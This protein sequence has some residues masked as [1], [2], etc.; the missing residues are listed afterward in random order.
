MASNTKLNDVLTFWQSLACKQS[1][2]ATLKLLLE[3]GA[4]INTKDWWEET[5]LITAILYRL[6]HA[7]AILL[8]NGADVNVTTQYGMTALSMV[9]W[10]HTKYRLDRSHWQDVFKQL[11][12]NG[13]DVHAVDNFGRT[14][15]IEAVRDGIDTVLVRLLIEHGADVNARDKDG[16]TPLSFACG[17]RGSLKTAELLRRLGAKE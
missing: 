4:D 1:T 12:Q 2:V 16:K 3:K 9:M 11:L 8:Q 13:A 6:W 14:P 5:P 17:E 15:L 7:I 10:R